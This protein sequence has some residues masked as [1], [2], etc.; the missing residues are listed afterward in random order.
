[1]KLVL[2]LTLLSLFF[3]SGVGCNAYSQEFSSI[4]QAS[5]SKPRL[6]Y[7]VNGSSSVSWCGNNGLLLSGRAGIEWIS[8]G[9]NQKIKVAEGEPFPRFLQYNCTPDGKWI[10]YSD[11]SSLRYDRE[12]KLIPC[13]E[14]DCDGEWDGGVEDLLRYDIATGKHQKIAV[15][16]G[17]GNYPAMAPTGYRVLLGARHSSL[18]EMP[19]PKWETTWFIED[20]SPHMASAWFQDSSGVVMT[21][22]NGEIQIEVFGEKG[23]H[24]TLATGFSNLSQLTTDRNNQVLFLASSSKAST[25]NL[26]RCQIGKHD[27][28]CIALRKEPTSITSYAKLNDGRLVYTVKN[29]RCVALAKTDNANG[30]CI[31]PTADPPWEWTVISASPDGKRLMLRRK[32]IDKIVAECVKNCLTGIKETEVVVIEL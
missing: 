4:A 15:V 19:E 2:Q 10:V 11:R 18:M 22:L 24:R 17:V 29:S 7:R 23:W 9:T 8:L 6:I 5:V 26:Y 32:K 31:T 16:R 28:A 30:A 13:E 14:L 20:W 27:W 21:E 25:V 12:Y 1:M 3:L